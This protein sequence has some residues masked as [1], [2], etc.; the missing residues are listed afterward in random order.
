L[1]RLSWLAFWRLQSYLRWSS[2][3]VAEP[4]TR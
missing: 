3:L 1:W 2:G 4:M